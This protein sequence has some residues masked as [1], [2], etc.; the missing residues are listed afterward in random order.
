VNTAAP[1]FGG[2]CDTLA[3]AL[4]LDGSVFEEEDN[5]LFLAV[6][7]TRSQEGKIVDIAGTIS[8][9]PFCGAKLEAKT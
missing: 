2:C 8:F 4:A 6:A 1:S 7:R 5:Q 9:C 3:R